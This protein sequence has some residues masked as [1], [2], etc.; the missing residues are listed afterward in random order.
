MLP[1]TDFSSNPNWEYRKGPNNE[2][3]IRKMTLDHQGTYTCQAQ[4]IHGPI[5]LKDINLSLDFSS[6]VKVKPSGHVTDEIAL[7][8]GSFSPSNAAFNAVN[9]HSLPLPPFPEI[10]PIPPVPFISTPF[11]GN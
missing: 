1:L 7:H 9:S 11:N 4:N 6:H 8:S 2:L 10:P 5:Q 3:I